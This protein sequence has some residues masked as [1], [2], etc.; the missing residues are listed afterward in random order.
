MTFP[1]ATDI[2]KLVAEI[3]VFSVSFPEKVFY[4]YRA[5]IGG[6]YTVYTKF[7]CAPYSSWALLYACHNGLANMVL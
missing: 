7:D 3:Q 2:N 1:A 5:E 6:R 4:I